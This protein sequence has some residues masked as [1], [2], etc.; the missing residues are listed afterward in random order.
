MWEDLGSL[1]LTGYYAD[2]AQIFK[3][4]IRTTH[5]KR[6]IVCILL[7]KKVQEVRFIYFIFCKLAT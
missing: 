4:L 2:F 6:N 3:Y 5:K 7:K 1:K